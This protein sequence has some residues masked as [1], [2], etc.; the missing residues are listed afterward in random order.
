MWSMSLFHAAVTSNMPVWGLGLCLEHHQV[1]DV[2]G[3]GEEAYLLAVCIIIDIRK[4]LTEGT[5]LLYV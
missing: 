4:P 2:D 5:L 1:P 3:C